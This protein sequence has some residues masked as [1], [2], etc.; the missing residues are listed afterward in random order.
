[1]SESR[2]RAGCESGDFTA[3]AHTRLCRCGT[4]KW[5]L[6]KPNHLAGDAVATSSGDRAP[7]RE[8]LFGR[9]PPICVFIDKLY[10]GILAFCVLVI[11][12]KLFHFL[13]KK[14]KERGFVDQPYPS[15]MSCTPLGYVHLALS[16]GSEKGEAWVQIQGLL[17]P[18]TMNLG[19]EGLCF[20]APQYAPEN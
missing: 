2:T 10:P 18:P 1:M 9:V 3:V 15:D 7:Q 16:A 11:Q 20:P 6:G 12:L 4:P 13:N 14:I 8:I 19:H 17:R 5:G